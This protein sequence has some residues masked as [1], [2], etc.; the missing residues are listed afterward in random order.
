M[1]QDCISHHLQLELKPK[2]KKCRHVRNQKS[3]YRLKRFIVDLFF[4]FVESRRKF[5][6]L[7][8]KLEL[9]DDPKDCLAQSEKEHTQN[10]YSQLSNISCCLT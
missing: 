2:K 9:D 8:L 4:F 5:S 6:V 1:L 3:D 7:Y 10:S